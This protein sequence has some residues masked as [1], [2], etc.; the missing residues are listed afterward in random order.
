MEN[1]QKEFIYFPSLSA[2]GFA[3]ALIK[4]EKLSSGVPCRFYSDEYPESF[5]HKYFLVTA[6]HYYKKIDI[7]DQM[8]L[9]KDVLAFGDSGGYQIATGALKYSDDLREKIFH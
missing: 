3:S 4:N 1:K 5:R 6:G 7:R 2:G 8:G 9:G